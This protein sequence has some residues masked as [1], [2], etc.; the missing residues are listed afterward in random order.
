MLFF[1]ANSGVLKIFLIPDS[2]NPPFYRTVGEKQSG[3]QNGNRILR[4]SWIGPSVRLEVGGVAQ[5]GVVHGMGLQSRASKAYA[6]IKW[7][8]QIG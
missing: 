8:S 4:R 6:G 1:S 3:I 7:P 2:F 5:G